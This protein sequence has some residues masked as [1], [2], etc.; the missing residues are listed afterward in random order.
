MDGWFYENI[1]STNVCTLGSWT[2]IVIIIQ[3]SHWFNNYFS[4]VG[5]QAIS[6]ILLVLLFYSVLQINSYQDVPDNFLVF[7][8]NLE[9]FAGTPVL[10]CCANKL[11]P[12]CAR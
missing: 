9:N 3:V 5:F 4:Y 8:G 10:L 1:M 7:P 6:R 11:I 12:A 2:G